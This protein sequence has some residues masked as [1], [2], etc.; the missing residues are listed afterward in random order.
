MVKAAP[1]TGHLSSRVILQWMCM[2]LVGNVAVGQQPFVPAVAGVHVDSHGVLRSRAVDRTLSRSA[3]RSGSEAMCQISLPRLFAELKT[4]IEARQ[5]IPTSMRLLDGMVKLEYV[6]VDVAANDLIIAGRAE[7]IVDETGLRPRGAISGRPVLRLDDLVVA[8]RTLGPGG[9]SRAF[10]CSIDLENAAIERIKTVYKEQQATMTPAN[11]DRVGR[12]LATA[13]GDQPVRFF[14]VKPD[15]QFALVCLEA[16]YIMKRLALGLDESPVKGVQKHLSMGGRGAGIYSRRWFCANY[17]P[18]LVSEAGDAYHIRGQGLRVRASDSAE[19]AESA[20]A[21]A[22]EFARQMTERFPLL[23][24]YIPEFADLWNVADLAYVASLIRMD[25]LAEKANWDMTWS[26]DPSGYQPA[27][28]AV[29]TSAETLVN[30]RSVRN[31]TYFMVGGVHFAMDPF[32]RPEQRATDRD[33]QIIRPADPI[34]SSKWSVRKE[35]STPKIK[36]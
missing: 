27:P 22:L 34:D 9:S 11:Y 18:L 8:L 35:A 33:R 36:K 13:C 17:E 24:S 16:D 32:L 31:T 12:T 1:M 6:F 3:N 15:C 7:P 19:G 14:G 10:G 28:C 20:S 23:A 30:L 25:R 29:P 2:L 5:Q 4:R 26:L 21:G